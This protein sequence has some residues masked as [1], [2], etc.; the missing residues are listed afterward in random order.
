MLLSVAGARQKYMQFLDDKKRM[1][2][3]QEKG[4]KRKSLLDE[5]EELKHKKKRIENEAKSLETEADQLA[6]KTENTGKLLLV[7]K[8]N[9]LCR[10]AKEKVTESTQLNATLESELQEL[11]SA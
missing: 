8:S 7:A 10:T 4:E 6:L 1:K 11:K 3:D 5:I 2:S 9:S